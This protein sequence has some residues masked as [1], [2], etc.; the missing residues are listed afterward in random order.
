MR[1]TSSY[2]LSRLLTILAAVLIWKVT[3]SVVLGYRNYVPPNFES[4]FLLGRE[5]YF[6]G[7]YR[8][9]FYTHLV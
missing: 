8:W 9:A 2:V 6:W 3:L 4:D 7:P 1:N 5:T